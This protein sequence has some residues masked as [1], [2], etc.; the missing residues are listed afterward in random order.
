MHDLVVAKNACK[1][2]MFSSFTPQVVENLIKVRGREK[3]VIVS[4]KNRFGLEEKD[5]DYS[6]IPGVAG[7]NIGSTFLN[8]ELVNKTHEKGETIGVWYN[9]TNITDESDL[10]NEIFAS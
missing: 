5:K 4:L 8:Q 1:K 3:Y 2:V 7:I 6:T 10:Y 9:E